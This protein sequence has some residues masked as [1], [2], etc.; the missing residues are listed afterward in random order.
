M[1]DVTVTIPERGDIWARITPILDA[2]KAREDAVY[3]QEYSFACFIGDAEV[4]PVEAIMPRER[5]SEFVSISMD[6]ETWR[7]IIREKMVFGC[8]YIDILSRPATIMGLP[9]HEVYP[10]DATRN[11]VVLHE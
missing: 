1:A 8:H 6:C 2:I 3:D 10:T 11:K 9:V 7:G 4:K 5:I